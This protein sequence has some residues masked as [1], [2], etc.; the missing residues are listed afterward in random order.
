[1]EHVGVLES[2]RSI[3]VNE[4]T[5]GLMPNL[6]PE[7]AWN[8]GINYTHKFR[9]N[10]RDA[11]LTMDLYHTRFENQVVLDLEN[12]REAHFYNLFG[13][14][15]SNS[16]QTEFNWD[17]NRRMDLRLAWRW[18]DVRT[19]YSTGLLEK[20]MVSRNRAFANIA[21]ATKEAEKGGQW[22]LDL[23]M[24]WIGSAR[25]P[26]TEVNPEE[27]VL[28]P[29]SDN[30]QQGHSQVTRVFNPRF[31]LYLGV[32]NITN[33]R[34]EAP[35]IAADQPFSPWFDAGLIWGPVFGRMFY[36][37]LRYTIQ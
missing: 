29:R 2:N 15:W 12:P 7:D 25:L 13:E 37:G 23:T 34:Q 32:E 27:Y 19:T 24:E 4:Q 26:S 3:R 14:S 5:E 17:M 6:L 9:L 36:G 22:K 11:S 30:F 33:F 28:N 18:L 1:M 20:P 16:V 21:Y 8:F 31:E 10:Y 35:I